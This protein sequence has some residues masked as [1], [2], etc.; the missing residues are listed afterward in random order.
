LKDIDDLFNILV[1]QQ[2][3]KILMLLDQL[4]DHALKGEEQE[5][6][7]RT[8]EV[9]AKWLTSLDFKEKLGYS[10]VRR[11]GIESETHGLLLESAVDAE[12]DL[13]R[14]LLTFKM[15]LSSLVRNISS[16]TPM[17]LDIF[18]GA[19]EIMG[20]YEQKQRAFVRIASS[21]RH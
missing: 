9:W 15:N 3:D 19:E 4:K 17:S 2:G 18:S 11:A 6:V 5:T 7:A 12:T 16:L 14:M 8:C 21:L 1:S 20:A 10:S 13:F